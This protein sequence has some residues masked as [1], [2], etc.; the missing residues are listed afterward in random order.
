MKA[1]IK[2]LG[3]I[4]LLVLLPKN[5]LA[6]ELPTQ[7]HSVYL[8]DM[9]NSVSSGNTKHINDLGKELYEQSETQFIVVTTDTLEDSDAFHNNLI[10]EWNLDEGR[11]V[12][13][14]FEG[15]SNPAIH[16]YKSDGIELLKTSDLASAAITYGHKEFKNG[17]YNKGLEFS[18]NSI[19]R[20][21]GAFYK[22]EIPGVNIEKLPRESH[23]RDWMTIVGFTTIV[24]LVIIFTTGKKRRLG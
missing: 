4:L 23:M 17:N 22:I 18:Y 13:L 15:S 16:L 10:D 24:F 11:N 20:M 8:Y 12:L 2:Y 1:Y 14:T 9:N 21:L 5:V 7:E 3:V 6:D 19:Y